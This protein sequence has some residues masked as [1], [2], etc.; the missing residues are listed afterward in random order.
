MTTITAIVTPTATFTLF[1]LL[2]A[3][4]LFVMPELLLLLLFE[5]G[6][7]VVGEVDDVVV[8]V[9]GTT[10]V[11]DVAEVIM[12]VV[13]DD[14]DCCCEVVVGDGDAVEVV[15]GYKT[16]RST[17]PDT[18]SNESEATTVTLI[19]GRSLMKTCPPIA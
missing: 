2:P 4:V 11:V 10:S 17:Y 12:V 14:D 19:V 15:G 9:S 1:S 18:S 13:N 5:E 6:D 8:V 3:F 7:S 16:F